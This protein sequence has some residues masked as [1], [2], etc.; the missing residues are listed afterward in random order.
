MVQ[1]P[2]ELAASWPLVQ[3]DPLE[4]RG[5]AMELALW[6]G[7]MFGRQSRPA[8]HSVQQ[9]WQAWPQWGTVLKEKRL[10]GPIEAAPCHKAGAAP[11]PL[12]EDPYQAG[13]GKAGGTMA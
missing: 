11:T 8:G 7:R 12:L 2:G 1:W 6:S 5:N 4:K 9:P 10:E 13:F 3:K